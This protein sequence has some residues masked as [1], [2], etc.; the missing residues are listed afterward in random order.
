LF[1]EELD[2]NL[3]N[4]ISNTSTL[5][6]HNFNDI[7]NGFNKLISQTIDL[8]APLKRYSRRQKRLLKKPSINKG[9]LISIKKKRAM[10]KSHFFHGTDV[11]KYLYK[12]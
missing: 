2:Q 1:N 10:F 9:I 6:R 11:Q 4:Y 5:T 3:I 12:K 7:F 8:H